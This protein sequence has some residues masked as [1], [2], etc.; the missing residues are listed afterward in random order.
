MVIEVRPLF[1]ASVG[2]GFGSGIAPEVWGRYRAVLWFPTPHREVRF[3]HDDAP[4][5]QRAHT[6]TNCSMRLASEAKLRF[7]SEFLTERQLL[8]MPS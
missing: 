1:A 6:K 8:N 5:M 2:V 3:R 4:S 7:G